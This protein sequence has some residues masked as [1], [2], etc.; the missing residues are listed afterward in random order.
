MDYKITDNASQNRHEITIEGV[1][2]R[3]EYIKAQKKILTHTKVP[4]ALGRKGVGS[5]LVAQ[6]LEDIDRQDLT[7][8]P[9]CPFVAL[10]LKCHSLRK[11]LVMK[12]S[13]MGKELTKK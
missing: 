9:L 5:A 11:R 8:V 1:N 3:I 7:L 12:G 6:V 10:Y 13:N 4:K 2:A